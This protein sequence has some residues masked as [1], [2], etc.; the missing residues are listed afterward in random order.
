MTTESEPTQS[1]PLVRALVFITSWLCVLSG[2]YHISA[3]YLRPLPGE[4]HPNM[5]MLL[6]YTILL[7]GGAGAISWS[8]TVLL[9]AEEIDEAVGKSVEYRPPGA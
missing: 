2:L 3:V 1:A 5:H 6:A 9:T 4:M 8:T 7:I